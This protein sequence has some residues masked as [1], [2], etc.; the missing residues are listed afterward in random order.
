VAHT[1]YPS[2]WDKS[3]GGLKVEA[4][5][6]Y[7]ITSKSQYYVGALISPLGLCQ[8][9][10]KGQHGGYN[11]SPSSWEAEA[12]RQCLSLGTTYI[13]LQASQGYTVRACLKRL[14]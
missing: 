4:S 1:H 11:L 6:D 12:G 13:E 14:F 9:V 3:T 8:T 5:L 7:L 2:T 10:F